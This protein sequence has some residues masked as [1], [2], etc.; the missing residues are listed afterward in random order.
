MRAKSTP[1]LP[2]RAAISPNAPRTYHSGLREKGPEGGYEIAT[3]VYAACSQHVLL[4]ARRI[5]ATGSLDHPRL[6]YEERLNEFTD[7]SFLPRS[8]RN[9]ILAGL[10]RRAPRG[11]ATREFIR[12]L[13][14]ALR[15]RMLNGTIPPRAPLSPRKPPREMLFRARSEFLCT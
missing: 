4:I 5:E 14:P 13:F 7:C 3:A 11:N 15:A 9:R 6:L 10:A 12:A 1:P 8:I 2:R